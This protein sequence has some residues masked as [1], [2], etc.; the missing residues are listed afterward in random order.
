MKTTRK[1]N[2]EL[3]RVR[4]RRE[5]CPA[6]GASALGGHRPRDPP[7]PHP[8]LVPG[9]VPGQH[10]ARARSQRQGG[11]ARGHSGVACRRGCSAM[12]PLQTAKPELLH[13]HPYGQGAEPTPGAP[14]L[15][16]TPHSCPCPP[17]IVG[18][19]PWGLAGASWN[20]R[21]AAP[22]TSDAV[23]ACGPCPPPPHRNT[24]HRAAEP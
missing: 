21:T 18:R 22:D 15:T 8:Y 7:L 14:L 10:P 12:C 5:V 17:S 6:S 1:H 24:L 2:L 20:E 16:D 19:S 23:S 11:G 9:W 3:G 4:S 13:P